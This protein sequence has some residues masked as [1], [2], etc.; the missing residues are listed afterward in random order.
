[1]NYGWIAVAAV[2]AALVML[3]ASPAGNAL[4][5][6]ARRPAYCD[7][8]PG[9]LLLEPGIYD[10]DHGRW[11]RREFHCRQ[12]GAIRKMWQQADTSAVLVR[13]PSET[14]AET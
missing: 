12:C 6:R 8:E 10:V 11:T 9:R 3:A 5:A 7:W 2:L 14:G 1:V 13:C 4:L